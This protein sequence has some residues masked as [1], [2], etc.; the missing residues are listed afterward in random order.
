MGIAAFVQAH[1]WWAMAALLVLLVLLLS[2]GVDWLARRV[3]RAE[4]EERARLRR[5]RIARD[6]AADIERRRTDL[7]H[8]RGVRG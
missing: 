5:Q 7:A 8:R 4:E 1:P 6:L 2:R 3:E